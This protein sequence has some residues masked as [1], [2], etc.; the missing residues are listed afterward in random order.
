MNPDWKA[1]TSTSGINYIDIL[2]KED[3]N[4]ALNDIAQLRKKT[5]IL[6]VSIHW[7]PNMKAEPEKNFID[8]A[9]DMIAQG[10]DIIHG[11]SAHNFQG[12]G[13]V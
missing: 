3:C 2:E 12:I 4:K 13:S 8:F 6:I 9:H 11:H 5:D 7:G 1:G 10:A